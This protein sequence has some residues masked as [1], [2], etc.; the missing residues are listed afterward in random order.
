MCFRQ[1]FFW[2]TGG[3]PIPPENSLLEMPTEE[4]HHNLHRRLFKNAMT[5]GAAKLGGM[6]VSPVSKDQHHIQATTP[7]NLVPKRLNPTILS[8]EDIAK[9]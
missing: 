2:I 3:T 6:G 9:L 5:H 4:I 7:H 8:G 1:W